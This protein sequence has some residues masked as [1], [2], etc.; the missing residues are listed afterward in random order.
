MAQSVVGGS[1][2]FST[3]FVTR[4][5]S[6][7][8]TIAV[9]LRELPILDVENRDAAAVALA[10]VALVIREGVV[11][12]VV[13]GDHEQVVVEADEPDVAD[14]AEAVLVRRRAV[15][16]DLHVLVLGPARKVVCEARVRDQVHLVG[17]RLLDPVE[18]PVHDRPASDRQQLLR[19]R[20]RERTQPR[21]VARGENQRLHTSAA[22]DCE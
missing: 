9:L 19:D 1:S 22:S 12:Q 8:S 17:A 3:K 11:E 7:T 21:R 15:V 14:C 2:G 6:S 5:C 20:V 4:S 13:S 18:D 10:P 16:V